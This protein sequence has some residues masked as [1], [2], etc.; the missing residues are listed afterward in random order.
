MAEN[1]EATEWHS[2]LS[3]VAAYR[4]SQYLRCMDSQELRTVSS[5]D[6]ALFV[7]VGD[8][9]V[10]RDLS[11]LGLQGQRGIGYD[12]LNLIQVI[13]QRLGIHRQWRAV[14]VGVGNLARALFRYQGF[15]AQGFQ[16][17]GLFDQDRQ[18]I[19][20]SLDG[21]TIES[22]NSL[23]ER[24]KQLQA[25]LGILT[26]PA[27]AA[28]S[29]ADQLIQGGVKGLLNFASVRLQVPAE[30]QIVSVDLTVQL[31]Q[32]AFLVQMQQDY[33]H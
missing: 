31:E 28:Q 15:Q 6:L 29:V 21:M 12:R 17:V 19:G 8:A 16:I 27:H 30:V 25:E 22:T 23:V 7:G 2:R 14:L 1:G 18:V 24:T 32:L 10:R 5:S 3:R 33:G 26:L 4:L 9:Q 20:T 13:R 11:A